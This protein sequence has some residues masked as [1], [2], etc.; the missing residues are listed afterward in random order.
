AVFVLVAKRRRG[1]DLVERLLRTAANRG[2]NGRRGFTVLADHLR[3]L[4]RRHLRLFFHLVG[5]AR[6]LLDLVLGVL[7]DEVE[8]AT[9]RLELKLL[10]RGHRL[11]AQRLRKG[12]DLDLF[13][14]RRRVELVVAVQLP[15]GVVAVDLAQQGQRTKHRLRDIP[16]VCR[17]DDFAGLAVL[18]LAGTA[19]S[20]GADGLGVDRER[21]LVDNAVDLV[22]LIGQLLG[23]EF[24]RT[25]VRRLP[26]EVFFTT[27]NGVSRLQVDEIA[28]S[29]RHTALGRVVRL[30]IR[31]D[32]ARHQLSVRQPVLLIED[33]QA[34]HRQLVGDPKPFGNLKHDE[35]DL[36]K[37]VFAFARDYEFVVFVVT[38]IDL[39]TGLV[40][41][42]LVAIGREHIAALDSE[43][44][45]VI[46]VD[47][48]IRLNHLAVA[49]KLAIHLPSSQYN[50]FQFALGVALPVVDL[51]GRVRRKDDLAVVVLF[52]NGV[53]AT[54]QPAG[55]TANEHIE[56][57]VAHEV[58]KALAA[59]VSRRIERFPPVGIIA[60]VGRPDNRVF[61]EQ[62]MTVIV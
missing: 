26:A 4:R 13:V 10:A 38:V 6:L 8:K 17:Q 47:V 21:H 55:T 58:S 33:V 27:G 36:A 34:R 48:R 23:D 42:I 51:L 9:N 28:L 56:K 11:Q 43:R 19:A 53:V 12:R 54:N 30:Q 2:A 41:V 7:A 1:D 22:T 37:P 40:G 29:D 3:N 44:L 32:D 24:E 15:F 25:N 52:A 20:D 39:I 46:A 31:L 18:D 14:Q 45:P 49:G 50:P 57:D 35:R 62:P 16:A 59:T 60:I 5:V 61:A